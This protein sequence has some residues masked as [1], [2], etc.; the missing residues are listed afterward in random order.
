MKHRGLDS[1]DLNYADDASSVCILEESVWL[2]RIKRNE[3]GWL[4]WEW[5]RKRVK[6]SKTPS[7][8]SPQLNKH[9]MILF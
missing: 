8:P 2:V 1:L 3:G 5:R 9:I 6:I 4:D 7:A